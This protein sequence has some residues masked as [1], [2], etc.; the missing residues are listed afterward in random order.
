MPKKS[1]AKFILYFIITFVVIFALLYSV[2]LV[3]EV[4]KPSGD[5]SLRTLWDKAQQQA[6][7]NQLNQGGLV[8]DTPSRIVI[9]QIGVDAP[10]SNPATTNA[11][12]LDDYLAEG[13]VRYPGSGLPGQGN[14]FIFGHSTGLAVVRNQAYKTFNNLGK[15]KVGDQIFVYSG[16]KK[17]VYQVTAVTMEPASEVEINFSNTKNML[18]LSTCNVF[19]AKEDR[20]IV[21]ADFQGLTF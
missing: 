14:M 6:V 1:Q 7:N 21:T 20:Y 5:E 16:D 18:T 13:A 8:S 4:I 12:T 17:Y 19:S 2:G 9:S 15:L 11:K 10:V 3:P